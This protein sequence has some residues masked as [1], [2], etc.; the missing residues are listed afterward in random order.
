MKRANTYVDAGADAVLVHSKQKTP[1][2]IVSFCKAW[3]GR[4]PLVLVSTSYPQLSFAD[5]AALGKVGLVICGNHAIRAAVVGVRRTFSRILEQG[6]IAGMEK[7]IV[8]VQKI[9]ELQG[10]GEMRDIEEAYLR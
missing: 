1:D 5:V 3:S 7:E 2:E 10:D 6:G 9:F 8:P 4:V